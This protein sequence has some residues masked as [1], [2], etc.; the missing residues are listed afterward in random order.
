MNRVRPARLVLVAVCVLTGLW[1]VLPSLVT[2][3]VSFS[4]SRSFV[5]PQQG[6]SSQWYTNF[7][8]DQRWLDALGN[9]LIVATLTAILSTALGTL[10][11]LA[12]DRSRF[13][14]R[15]V[16]GGLLMTPAIV[17]VILLALGMYYVLLRWQLV[18]TITGLVLG[19]TVL[20]LPLVFRTVSASLAQ[21]DRRLEQ[22]AA[23]LGARPA[24]VLWQ[25]TL[26]MI[27]SGMIAG[28]VFAFLGSFDEVVI[29]VF[30][31]SPTT[32][33]LPVLM[34][35]AVTRELDPTIAAASSLILVFTTV[36]I[37]GGLRIGD[38]EATTRA[39]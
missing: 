12:V 6:L 14:G 31:S 2:I 5:M 22:A 16:V 27:R 4:A 30:L 1:L 33:T 39:L 36:L 35:N 13:R 3:P 25:I 37:L 9:S 29:S 10:A 24:A 8:T 26:P 15:G 34:F 21:A 11:A 19:H 7:F 32:Q 20:G 17:P 28:S 38:K 18:G 23:S